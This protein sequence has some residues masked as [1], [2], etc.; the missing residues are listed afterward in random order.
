MCCSPLLSHELT[1]RLQSATTLLP[2]LG[3]LLVPG[4]GVHERGGEVE[5]LASLTLEAQVSAAF[6]G[7]VYSTWA[8]V[9]ITFPQRSVMPGCGSGRAAVNV[10]GK[11]ARVGMLGFIVYGQGA[12]NLLAPLRTPPHCTAHLRTPPHCT[13]H[14]HTPPHCTAHLRTTPHR[15]ALHWCP[16]KQVGVQEIQ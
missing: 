4:G 12:H 15:T 1:S 14:L 5:S 11:R 7:T 9:F 8:G 16:S 2:S 10:G 6:N 13:T 3:P